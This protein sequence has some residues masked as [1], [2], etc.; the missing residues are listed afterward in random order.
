MFRRFALLLIIFSL[1]SRLSAS[2]NEEI[3]QEIFSALKVQELRYFDGGVHLSLQIDEPVWERLE[4]GEKPIELARYENN[5]VLEVEGFPSIPVTGSLF[6]IPPNVGAR[7]EVTNSEF[8]VFKNI[9]YAIFTGEDGAESLDG[10]SDPIDTWYPGTL[11]EIGE[12]AVFH[13]FRVANM[14]T[15]PVQ[16]NTST[17]E[18][19]VYSHIVVEIYFEGE[20]Q[21]NSLPGYPTAIS[22][23]FLPWYRMLMDWN[24]NELDEFEVYRGKVQV[25]MRDDEAVWSSIESWI[26]WKLQRGWELEFLTDNDV[27]WS[28]NSIKSELED[29]YYSSAHHFD[30]IVII[31][32]DTGGF[33]VPP[34][35]GSGYGG[36]DL[37]YTT[38]AG[39]DNLPDVHIGRIS[40]ETTTELRAYV[41]KVLT[42]ERDIDMNDTDWYLRGGVH[43][44]SASTGTSSIYVGQYCRNAMLA[45]GFTR[46]DTAWYNDGLGNTLN[47]ME[48]S[49]NRG[50]SYYN[51]RGFINSGFNAGWI[52]GFTN[53]DQNP[54]VFDVTCGTGNWSL[55]TG[56]NEIWMRAGSVNQP[57]GA[58]GSFGTATSSTH[59]R[60][61]NCLNGGTAFTLLVQRA[62][63]L[64]QGNTGAKVNMYRNYNGNNDNYWTSFLQWLNLMGD[65]T[66][67]IWTGIPKELDVAGVRNFDLGVNSSTLRV[68]DDDTGDPVE[69]AWVTFYKVDD[70]EETIIRGFTDTEG[71]VTI[72]GAFQSAGVV[73][74]TISAQH[75]APFQ[76]EV[77]IINPRNQVGYESITIIDDNSHGTS[78]NSNGIPQAGETIGLMITAK[79]YGTNGRTDVTAEV[80]SNDPRIENI[81]NSI[82]YGDLARGELSEGNAVILV[83]I[84]ERTQNRWNIDFE[85]VF[86]SEEDT[87]E[88]QFSLTVAS[89]QFSLVEIDYIGSEPEPGED[90]ELRITVANIG[91]SNAQGICEAQLISR[92][93]WMTIV[94]GEGNLQAIDIGDEGASTRF[95]VHAHEDATVGQR[96]ETILVI[97]TSDGLVDTMSLFV[98]IGD[99]ESTD[100]CGPDSYG[101]Y[102]FENTDD[103][104]EYA[105]DYDWV[106]IRDNGT[107]LNIYDGGNNSDDAAVIDL[108][109][110]VQYYGEVFDE[111]TVTGNGFVAMGNQ[112]M[113]RTPRNWTIP[114]PLGPNFMIA[115]YW[116]E[117]RCNNTVYYRYDRNNDRVIIEWY[118]VTDY[119][120]SNPCTFEVIFYD[121]EG[122]HITESG[123]TEILFQYNTMNHSAGVSTDTPYWTTGIENGDQSGGILIAFWSDEAPGAAEI[124]NGRAILFTTNVIPPFG[125]IEGLVIDSET[126][127]PLEGVMVRSSDGFY[128]AITGDDGFYRIN[129]VLEGTY[130]L[131]Y[132]FE[133]YNTSAVNDIE[134]IAEET[135][136]SNLQ[137]TY[138]LYE[139]DT[140]SILVTVNP[141]SFVI[142]PMTVR[143]DGTGD[144]AYS[145]HIEFTREATSTGKRRNTSRRIT[146][147]GGSELDNPWD[148]LLEFPLT[149]EESRNK[150]VV[151]IGDYFY[152][153]GSDNFDPLGPNKIYLYDRDGEL[154]STM[155]Q[156]VPDEYRS[157]AGFYGMTYDGEYLYGIDGNRLFT[158][159]VG[160]DSIEL[161][162]NMTL[163]IVDA[164]YI[165]YDENHDWFWVGNAR[166]DI[167]AI[168]R[169]GDIEMEIPQNFAP[170]GAGW[171]PEDQDGF[172]IYL[173]GRVTGEND[174]RIMKLNADTGEMRQVRVY[175][176]PDEELVPSGANVTFMWNPFYW[177]LITVIDDN[178]SDRVIVWELSE[179]TT[180]AEVINP[181]GSVD[182]GDSLAV[183]IRLRSTGLP[184]ERMYNCRVIFEHNACS[185]DSTIV[186][187]TMDT[188]DESS[189]SESAEQ[190][191]E[192]LLGDIYPNPFNPVTTVK[193]SLKESVHVKAVVYNLIGQEVFKLI[194][195]RM[196]PGYHTAT[197]DGSSLSSGMYFLQFE[198]GPINEMKKMLLMK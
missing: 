123:D 191:S 151:F 6:R 98:N 100:P 129:E 104:P 174:T 196:N 192:W 162:D 14:I 69:G 48:T 34:G 177:T 125:N 81:I 124:T 83:E 11:A 166:T 20:D 122:D 198:A 82:E 170:R 95:E 85:L 78:G 133:C 173:L 75:Y 91:G 145:T 63:C 17:R 179:Y 9:D 163:P 19:R 3:Q 132:M 1:T 28:A 23:S 92:S 108:P 175:Y 53:T 101:Y 55:S 189:I 184:R 32:D 37:G 59:T 36:G 188:H 56:I 148:E 105:P 4:T 62:L 185:E 42:Y 194:D 57:K 72:N 126:Q 67:W 103:Y 190:P 18:V 12:P 110:D 102:A 40:V 158:M 140:D 7:V 52:N 182:P 186:E 33:S 86:E 13:D 43:A 27:Q 193:F 167:T 139:L 44:S 131:Q 161:V 106:E 120:G 169:D 138:P 111:I 181:S 5:G 45:L 79:N 54:V 107:N 135:I 49:I 112:G 77:N 164:G 84:D 97:E 8:Q 178:D 47:R 65:P 73:T 22:E 87:D 176:D 10:I 149:E 68:R 30:Y 153:S 197:F 15:Y 114:S 127:D 152:V 46:V 58:I 159:E 118:R 117:R 150:G 38:I 25:V 41:N 50:I 24:E 64:G 134:V 128:T 183:L 60:Y 109:F 180:W 137:M 35:S 160:E 119:Y 155:D 142:V 29:R 94:N 74:V 130:T 88:S 71:L 16:V 168:N 156:P 80:S 51:H 172:K 39:N 113:M 165:V 26:E 66:V 61:N 21:R 99:R 187:V 157:R 143:N 154:I 195:D 2:T 116:D 89:V 115:P 121:Q 90:G 146:E 96:A 144:L 31:G 136:E 76:Q 70:D 171:Y 147:G 93:P 141:D